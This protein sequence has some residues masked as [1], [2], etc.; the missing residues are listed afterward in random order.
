MEAVVLSAN[1]V[2]GFNRLCL[3][4][5]PSC[6]NRQPDTITGFLRQIPEISWPIL[7]G[8]SEFPEGF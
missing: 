3:E 6:Q 5:S 2:T 8:K 7:T 1:P 4:L